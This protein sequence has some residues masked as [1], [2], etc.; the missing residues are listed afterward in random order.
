MDEFFT[1]SI[2]GQLNKMLVANNKDFDS[3]ISM[4]QQKIND[5]SDVLEW[6]LYGYVVAKLK[7]WQKIYHDR[8]E[9]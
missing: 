2:K 8:E 3:L 4:Y 9:G 1:E 7:K 5:A 6:M